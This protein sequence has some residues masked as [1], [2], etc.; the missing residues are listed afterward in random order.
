[1]ADA[2]LPGPSCPSCGADT[3]RRFS[4]LV[5]SIQPDWQEAFDWAGKVQRGEIKVAP[6][7]SNEG[8]LK[9]TD[10]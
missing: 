3:E 6:D 7:K 1:M 9:R 10:V 4:L 2:S 5:W 8:F